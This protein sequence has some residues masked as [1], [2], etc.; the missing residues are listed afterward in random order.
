MTPPTCKNCGIPIPCP[1]NA[2]RAIRRGYGYCGHSCAAPKR[3]PFADRFMANVSPEPNTGCWIW[4][5]SIH[6]RTGYGQIPSGGATATVGKTLKAHRAAFELF[7]GKIEIGLSVCHTCDNRW[8]VN[9]DHLF[10][11]TTAD[12]LRD[13]RRKDRH[14]RGERT[15][16]AKLTDEQVR[17]ILCMS[18]SHNSIARQFGVSASIIARI[19]KRQIWR[20]VDPEKLLRETEAAA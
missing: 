18:G 19:R 7:K 4:T 12:N 10:L 5:G 11:G 14:T 16:W 15:P 2:R 3:A 8:C 9:P 20:H 13:M 17:A 6:T 1:I